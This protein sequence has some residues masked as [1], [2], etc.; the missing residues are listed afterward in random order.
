MRVGIVI[1][2]ASG[3]VRRT[4]ASRETRARDALQQLGLQP[5]VGVTTERGH[6]GTLARSMLDAHADMVM[7]WGGDGTVNEVASVL[8]STGTPLAIVPGGSGNGL[9]RSLGVPLEPELAIARAI[10]GVNRQ[11]DVGEVDGRLFFNLAGVGFDAHVARLF[12]AGRRRGLSAYV[13]TSLVE[14][15]RYRPECYEISWDSERLSTRALLVVMANGSQYGCGAQIAPEA[16]PDDGLLML[17]VVEPRSVWRGVLDARHLFNG[18]VDRLRGV[19]SRPVRELTISAR[20]PIAVHLDG[21]AYQAGSRVTVRLR[22]RAM[23]FRVPQ[24]RDGDQNVVG[25]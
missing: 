25:R 19:S 3:P 8:A 23:V 6:A 2:P 16:Q 7:V 24:A 15:V 5:I 10:D 22:P 13:W 4:R 20:R 18:T 12:N 14:A 21:E 1:N 11:L 9:A 17:V